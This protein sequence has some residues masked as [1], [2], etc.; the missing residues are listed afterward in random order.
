NGQQLASSIFNEGVVSFENLDGGNYELCFT[1]DTLSGFERCAGVILYEPQPLSVQ[2]VVNTSSS[3]IALELNGGDAFEITLNGKTFVTNGSSINLPLDRIENKIE[4]RGTQDCQGVYTETII[5]SNQVFI[6]P[7]PVHNGK[8]SIYLGDSSIEV[9]NAEL[10]DF[11]GN[12]IYNKEQQATS[13]VIELN[14]NGLRPGIYMV[15]IRTENKL[16]T[17]K[18]VIR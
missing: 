18:L 4:V 7:N 5:L 12:K 15:Q 6:Y 13:G 16:I 14:V 3:E 2:S 17:H 8:V 10:Y 1:V 9:A 11:S